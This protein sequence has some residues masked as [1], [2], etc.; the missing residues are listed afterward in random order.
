MKCLDTDS[1]FALGSK[2]LLLFKL[3]P[4]G[5]CD[6]CTS[7]FGEYLIDLESYLL[8]TVAFAKQVQRDMCM[9]CSEECEV[10]GERQLV[11]VDC[12][13]CVDECDN[14]NN[15]M[16]N[17]YEDASN[18][19]Q[20]TPIYGDPFDDSVPRLYAGPVCA[21]SG[22]KINIGVFTDKKYCTILEQI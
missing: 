21:S 4:D 11:D 20:R 9:A 8:A 12:S 17:G 6:V 10:E 16:A 1:D 14:I 18:Y 13:T 19:V 2:P 15:M 3:C 5:T 22:S 7:N